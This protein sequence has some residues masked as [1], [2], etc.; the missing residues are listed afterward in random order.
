MASQS[1]SRSP[2]SP[3]VIPKDEQLKNMIILEE[4]KKTEL[5]KK[6]YTLQ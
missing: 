2:R 5:E 6:K 1:P 3:R 4:D